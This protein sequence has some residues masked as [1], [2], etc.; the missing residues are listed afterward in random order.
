MS[1]ETRLIHVRHI[2]DGCIALARS[3]P[4]FG[5]MITLFGFPFLKNDS[6]FSGDLLRSHAQAQCVTWLL[7]SDFLFS[8]KNT[9]FWG[10]FIALARSNT[11]CRMMTLFGFPF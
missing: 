7:F 4:M 9:Y 5:L 10:R 8:K 11:M 2:L 3:G 6:F 1:C